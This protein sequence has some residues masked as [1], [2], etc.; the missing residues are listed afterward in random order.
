MEVKLEG[1]KM[2][3]R[4]SVAAVGGHPWLTMDANTINTRVVFGPMVV[5]KLELKHTES[6]NWRIDGRQNKGLQAGAK[7]LELKATQQQTLQVRLLRQ[8]PHTEVGWC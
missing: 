3:T 2:I 8:T 1:N 7:F 4:P 5:M 6:G